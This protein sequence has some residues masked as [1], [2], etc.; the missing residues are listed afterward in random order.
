MEAFKQLR[1][2]PYVMAVSTLLFFSACVDNRYNLDNDHLDKT[3]VLSPNGLTVPLGN[4]EKIRLYDELTKLFAGNELEFSYESD[5]TLFVQYKGEFDIDIP[6]LEVPEIDPVTIRSDIANIPPGVMSFPLPPGISIPIVEDIGEYKIDTLKYSGDEGWHITVHSVAFDVC[7]IIITTGFEGITFPA[8]S[9]GKLHLSVEFPPDIT[10][11][12]GNNRIERTVDIK[13]LVKNGNEEK[14]FYTF[15]P[16][17]VA[18][19][20]YNENTDLKYSVAIETGNNMTVKTEDN[21]AFFLKLETTGIAPS[22]FKGAVAI[23]Q[24]ISDS[25]NDIGAFFDSFNDDN[26][27]ALYN[28]AMGLDIESNIGLDFGLDVNL[29]VKNKAGNSKLIPV[30]SLELKKPSPV[31]INNFRKT[32]FWLS[33]KQENIPNNAIWKD[34]K[35]DELINYRPYSLNYD[36]TLKTKDDDAVLFFSHMQSRGNYTLKLPF[37][38]TDL[39]IT[40]SDTIRD[41]FTT[42]IYKSIF[43]KAGPKDSLEVMSDPVDIYF[44]QAAPNSITLLVDAKVLKEDGSVLDK[45]TISSKNLHNGNGDDNKLSIIVKGLRSMEEAKHLCFS[46]SIQKSNTDPV[47]LTKDDY[48]HIKGLKFKSS[49]GYHFEL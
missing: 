7:N 37:S 24:C 8:G 35:I 41:V 27:L 34:T 9:P 36:L 1:L 18:S 10:F 6:K 39:K 32:Q 38:F 28:P 23:N 11:T 49:G 46:F 26:V 21:I 29:K 30:P 4:V 47:K 31:G 2:T 22:V 42:D 17:K 48:I 40:V 33:P 20:A 19:Y 14:P 43:E 25:I 45:V 44:K 15:P 16:L 13:D 5:G 3:C 12:E